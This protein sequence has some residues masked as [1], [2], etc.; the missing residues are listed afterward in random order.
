MTS[1]QR[2]LRRR[3]SV[4]TAALFAVMALG[5]VGASGAQ[6]LNWVHG[7]VGETFVLSGGESATTSGSGGNLFL[8][9][10]VLG[11]EVTVECSDMSSTGS[12]AGGGGGSETLEP[13]GCTVE[14][15]EHCEVASF[16]IEG[17]RELV[18]VS[19][20]TYEK[21][22]PSGGGNLGLLA[23]SGESCVFNE[24]E[25]PLSGGLASL[26]STSLQVNR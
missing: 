10:E 1:K 20:K 19:G 15:P 5:A 6:A 16:S 11:A 21:L 26:P 23:L 24:L 3:A 25:I 8:T 17:E 12:I 13:S 18:Q 4:L 2:S 9:G 7:D 14:E 22:V